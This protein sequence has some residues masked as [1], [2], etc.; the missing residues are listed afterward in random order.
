M[1]SSETNGNSVVMGKKL[2]SGR[3]NEVGTVTENAGTGW[4]WEI[5]NDFGVVMGDKCLSLCHSLL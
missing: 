5:Q 4:E 2:A 1:T 3:G